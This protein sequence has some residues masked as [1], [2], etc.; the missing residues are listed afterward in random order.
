M[1]TEATKPTAKSS[2]LNKK[3]EEEENA[4]KQEKQS[5]ETKQTV[6]NRNGF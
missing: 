5:Q 6:N 2:G 4:A 1:K 3:E